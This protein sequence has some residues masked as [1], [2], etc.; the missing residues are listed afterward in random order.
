[1]LGNDA[2]ILASMEALV[3]GHYLRARTAWWARS[4]PPRWQA[5]GGFLFEAG[6]LR[7]ADGDALTKK[8]DFSAWFTNEYL[9]E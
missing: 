8:P 5:I 4:I 7:D 3:E 1:M 9:P 6:I 2:L